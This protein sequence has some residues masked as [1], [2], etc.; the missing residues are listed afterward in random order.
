[1]RW[2]GIAYLLG[3]LAGFAILRWLGR[4]GQS[5][6]TR[7]RLGDYLSW[8]ALGVV[9][10]GRLGYVLFYDP[11]YFAAHPL[12]IPAL[13]HGGMSFHGGLLGVL[14][15]TWLYARRLGVPLLGIT[16][17]LALAVPPGLFFGRLANF[18]N[19]ELYGRVT[20][21]PW[22][23]VFPAGGPAARHPSQLYEALLEGPL[24]WLLVFWAGRGPSAARGTRSAAFL[25]GY[26]ILRFLVEFTREPDAHLGFVLGPF[27]MGQVLSA[28]LVAAGL[29]LWVDTRLRKGGQG[30]SG[31]PPFP[32]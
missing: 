29:A 5:P 25:A 24:L 31:K 7:E 4:R 26:G 15:A 23:M 27:S 32:G 1:M 19:G 28:A 2:Y 13:W 11:A 22:A 8:A 3:F 6:L 16:D 10:G 21:V 18:V 17:A 12:E 20:S 30:P 14:G 9:A